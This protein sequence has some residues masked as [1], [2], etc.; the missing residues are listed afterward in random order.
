MRHS[1]LLCFFCLFQKRQYYNEYFLT[2]PALMDLFYNVSAERGDENDE[3]MSEIQGIVDLTKLPYEF[4]KAMQLL[5]EITATIMAPIVNGSSLK[6]NK[7]GSMIAT[8]YPKGYEALSKLPVS[9]YGQCTGIIA[10][11]SNDGMVYHSRNFD[12]SPVDLFQYLVYEASFQSGGVEIFKAQ[13]MAGYTMVITGVN[14]LGT[15]NG[16]ALER[17]T[18]FVTTI[19]QFHEVY[20]NL[21]NGRELQGWTYRTTLLNINNYDDAVSLLSGDDLYCSTEFTILSGVKKGCILSQSPQGLAHKMTLGDAN[22]FEQPVSYII[23]TNFDYY[24]HDIREFF[25]PTGGG[26]LQNHGP[27]RRIAAQTILNNTDVITPQVL[28]EVMNSPYVIADTVW[29]GIISVEA[30]LWNTSIPDYYEPSN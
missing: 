13:M 9:H 7:D 8:T 23:M 4:I 5:E 26:G 10:M 17:N 15:S 20:H 22:N 25:D 18:R 16:Y 12:N 11:N 3:M 27:T 30:N 29:Q 28:Y 21:Y 24:W 6:Q 2:E 1:F 19:D 14:G